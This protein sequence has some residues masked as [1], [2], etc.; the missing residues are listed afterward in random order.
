MPELVI[1][2]LYP[3]LLRTYG[4]RGNIL[5]LAQRAG[6]RGIDARVVHVTRGEQL[7]GDARIVLLGGGSDRIQEIVGPDLHA[8]RSQLEELARDGRVIVGVCGGYQF[9]GHS[10]R[11]VDGTMIDGLGLLDITTVA[12]GTR[13]I[14]RTWATATLGGITTTLYGFENHAGRTTLGA[15]AQPLARTPK[16]HGNNGRDGTEGAIAGTIVGTYLHGPV[17]PLNPALS[18]WLISTALGGIEL[19]PLPDREENAARAARAG[20]KR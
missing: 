2:H 19:M 16:G 9:L 12:A 3:D 14:G 5:S 1:V 7:P 10:Y 6:A 17:L 11:A 18:D 13:L 8:R 15:G 20:L 4:D